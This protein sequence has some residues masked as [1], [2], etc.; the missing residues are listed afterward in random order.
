M[1]QIVIYCINL[2][3]RKD[4]W[5][6][7]RKQFKLQK[8]NA[9]RFSAIENKVYPHIWA[10]ESHK[11]II[12]LSLKN[13]YELVCVLE[14]D[15]QIVDDFIK[16]IENAI[17]Q[18]PNDWHIIYLWGLVCRNAKFTKIN[19]HISKI[20]SISCAYGI[21]YSRKCFK[22]LI[23]I[24]WSGERGFKKFKT[25]DDWLAFD[26]QNKYPCYMTNKILVEQLPGYSD[27][28]KR[29]KDT[30]KKYAF[31]FWMYSHGFSSLLK[32]A[33][34][35]GEIISLWNRRKIK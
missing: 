34:V 13:H 7:C 24:M 2:S 26:Y 12:E 32:W 3:H 27:I 35:V 23:K 17:L 33:W 11:K 31:R 6:K 8:I 4:R 14:D 21:I 1:K 22:N 10:A 5:A 15:V 9:K 28:E 25:F 20:H 29:E 30:R 18:T 19:R 16:K